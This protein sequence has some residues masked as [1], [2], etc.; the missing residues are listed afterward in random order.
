[1]RASWWRRCMEQSRCEEVDGIADGVRKH[2][3]LDVARRAG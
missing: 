3:H 2:L 1:M